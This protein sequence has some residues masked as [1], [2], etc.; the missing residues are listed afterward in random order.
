MV[1]NFVD[2]ANYELLCKDGTKAPIA[3]YKSCHLAKVPAHA[4]VSRNDP[5][6]ATSIFTKLTT[7]RV[8]HSWPT[9]MLIADMTDRISF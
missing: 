8:R 9:Q 6:L 1:C 7:V 3:N 5:D 4:V 2:G